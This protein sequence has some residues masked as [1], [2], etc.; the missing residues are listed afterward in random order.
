M[1]LAAITER[2]GREIGP[3][4]SLLTRIASCLWFLVL[5]VLFARGLVTM[6]LVTPTAGSSFSDWSAVL[7]RCCMVAFFVTLGW[8][9]LS[10]PPA[11]AQRDGVVPKII[12]W[13][14]TYS[15]WLIPFLP[16]GHI[17][18]TLQM[19]SAC[20]SLI[21]S[22]SIIYAVLYLG[23]SFSIVPQARKLVIGGPYRF[24]RHPLYVAEELAVI[25]V[26]IQI[27]WYAAALFLS[28]HIGLQVQRMNY[29]E[30]LLC[31]VFPDY[32]AYAR[33]TARLIPGVW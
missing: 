14:G 23:K 19:V 28:L 10:R 6:L 33:R 15:V 27:D 5:T 26:L 25:G 16:A 18:P 4:F 2:K 7:S 20:I 8:L 22:T 30:S 21:G 12:A 13:F 3:S 31:A 17:S 11:S 24:V 9:M 32:E 29:E 1:R